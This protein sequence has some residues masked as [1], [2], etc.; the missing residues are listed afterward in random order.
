MGSRYKEDGLRMRRGGG[1]WGE[2]EAEAE[3]L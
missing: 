3:G 1:G 2:E